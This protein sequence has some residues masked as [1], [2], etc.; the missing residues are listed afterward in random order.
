MRVA[1]L[2]TR[3]TTGPARVATD[4][5]DHSVTG[6][7][8]ASMGRLSGSSPPRLA[9]GH[10]PGAEDGVEGG[11]HGVVADQDVEDSVVFEALPT[12]SKRPSGQEAGPSWRMPALPS[13]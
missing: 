11:P 2:P 10:W 12:G 4:S 6:L 3:R 1:R 7:R 8:R 5:G 13:A 9:W